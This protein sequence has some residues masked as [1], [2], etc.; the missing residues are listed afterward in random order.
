M[1]QNECKISISCYHYICIEILK[2]VLKL[3][4]KWCYYYYEFMSLAMD[5]P[6]ET[7]LYCSQETFIKPNTPEKCRNTITRT[8]M[9]FDV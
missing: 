1:V 3:A 7:K 6:A 9:I 2:F 4:N 8:G 5:S